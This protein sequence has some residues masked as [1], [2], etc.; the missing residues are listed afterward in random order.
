MAL[1]SILIWGTKL[2]QV[3][4]CR[5]KKRQIWSSFDCTYTSNDYPLPVGESPHFLTWGLN[6]PFII[7]KHLYILSI[8][9]IKIIFIKET[10]T[11]EFSTVFHKTQWFFIFLLWTI[12]GLSSTPNNIAFLISFSSIL[13]PFISLSLH[14]PVSHTFL[15]ILSLPSLSFNGICTIAV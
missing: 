5:K 11:D 1:G 4:Q 10:S 8:K 12:H 14:F 13:F 7:V 2:L 15:L 3:S 6:N 9:L